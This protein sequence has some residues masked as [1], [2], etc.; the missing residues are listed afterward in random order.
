M[1]NNLIEAEDEN[2]GYPVWENV[3]ADYPHYSYWI[4]KEPLKKGLM[5][6][7]SVEYRNRLQE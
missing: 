2:Q 1:C 3:V 4:L 6:T 7:Y 5:F